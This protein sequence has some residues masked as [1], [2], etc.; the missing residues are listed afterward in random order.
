MNK[1][2][3]LN[4]LKESI[5]SMKSLEKQ[6]LQINKSNEKTWKI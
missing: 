1:K 2:I 6:T 3:F 4:K 5:A